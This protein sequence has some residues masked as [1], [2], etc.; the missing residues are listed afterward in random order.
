MTTLDG[1][2]RIYRIIRS[3]RVSG[4]RKVIRSNMTL[5]DAQ[6][7]CRRPDTRKEGVWFDGYDYMRGCAPK[8]T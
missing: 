5:A 4:R 3:Y 2:P 7:W 6:A 1:E 8:E